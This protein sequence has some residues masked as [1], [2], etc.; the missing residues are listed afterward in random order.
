MFIKNKISITAIQY[1][2]K[3]CI[4][5]KSCS[6][7]FSTFIQ[8]STL[9]FKTFFSSFF[10]S[11]ESCSIL[12]DTFH[13]HRCISAVFLWKSILIDLIPRENWS[14]VVE[15][16]MTLSYT[17]KGGKRFAFPNRLALLSFSFLSIQFV[18]CCCS[19]RE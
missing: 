16:G 7:I 14:E 4:P 17:L 13:I 3:S 10:S 11:L 1:S 2:T 15:E 18:F 9:S 12:L 19:S 5:W 6:W 8:N